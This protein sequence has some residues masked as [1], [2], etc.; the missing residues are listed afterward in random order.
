V[1]KEIARRQKRRIDFMTRLYWAGDGSVSEFVSAYDIGAD[2]GVPETDIRR[3]VEY[4]EERA[5]IK[6]D[7]HKLG[8]IRI[9]A[10]GIDYVEEIEGSEA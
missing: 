4:L 3:L 8:V 9:T 1:K 7:D 2:I 10:N 6:V 5:F